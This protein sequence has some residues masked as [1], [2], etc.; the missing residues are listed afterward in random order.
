MSEDQQTQQFIADYWEREIVPALTDYIR[1]P[2]VSSMFDPGMAGRT[3][4]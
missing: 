3:D 1:I 2:N 4:T